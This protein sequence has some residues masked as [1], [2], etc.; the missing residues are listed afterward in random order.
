MPELCMLP[1]SV[2]VLLYDFSSLASCSNSLFTYY[3][4]FLQ[5]ICHGIPDKR[6][7]EEG[8]IVN[9]DVSAY[10]KGYHGDLNETYVV[11][12]VDAASKKLIKAAHDVRFPSL[13]S[14]LALHQTNRF[15]TCF[16]NIIS[17]QESSLPFCF[18]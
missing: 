11:G 1:V 5:V 3:D 2:H 18:S 8:D 15:I 4:A 9:V 14:L 7:L 6:P 17:P 10:Y 13:S 16:L 12:Q